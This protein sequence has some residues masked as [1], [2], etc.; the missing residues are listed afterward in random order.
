[1][2]RNLAAGTI[3]RCRLL[4]NKI[5]PRQHSAI[6]GAGNLLPDVSTVA[7]ETSGNICGHRER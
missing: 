6:A 2:D 3:A 4:M 7:Q 1:M 5:L